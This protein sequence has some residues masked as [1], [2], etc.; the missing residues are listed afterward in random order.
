MGTSRPAPAASGRRP[1]RPRLALRGLALAL[2]AASLAGPAPAAAQAAASGLVLTVRGADGYPLPNARILLDGA[3]ARPSTERDGRF[4]LAELAAGSHVVSVSALGYRQARMDVQLVP[5]EVS[6]L[7]VTLQVQPLELETLDVEATADLP[8]PLRDFYRRRSRGAGT[9]F[10]RQQIEVMQPRVLTD[11]LRRVPGLQISNATG[12]FGS[13][14]SASMARSGG[15]RSCTVQYYVNGIPFPVAADV[16]INNFIQPDDVAAVEVYSG[17][18]R[19][20]PQFNSSTANSR[21][22][23]VA[24]W[25]R[26]ALS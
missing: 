1:P 5:G 19:I 7:A 24:I 18:A 20:P 3:A 14:Q 21:C 10:T 17:A 16:G 23:V 6:R 15:P 9:F 25:T 11:V 13:S 4:Q 22:G 12:P 26:S 2:L 8:P